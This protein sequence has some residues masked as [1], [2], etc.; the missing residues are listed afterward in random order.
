MLQE[1][2]QGGG[3]QCRVHE[4][5][6]LNSPDWDLSIGAV[7]QGLLDRIN[8]GE[9]DV[10]LVT[11]PCSTWSRV[12]GANCRGPPAIRS[13]AYPWG[14]PWLSA[15][16]HK[17][18]DLGNILVIFMLDVL[19][20]L[21]KHP[22]TASGRLVII[23]D[24]RP[25]DLG[26][27]RCEEDGM[28][29]EP[30]SIWQ[31]DRMRALLTKFASLQL[32]TVVFNQSCWG[33]P[34]RKPTRLISN[35]EAL[36]KWG[37]CQW[38]I[39][40]SYRNYV[41]PILDCSCKTTVTLARSR[42]DDTFRTS[43][44]SIYPVAMEAALAKA[45]MAQWLQ[46]PLLAKVGVGGGEEGESV[47]GSVQ[48]GVKR[49]SEEVDE[50]EKKVEVSEPKEKRGATMESSSRRVTPATDPPIQVGYKGETRALHDGAGLCSPG[51]WPVDRRRLPCT[52]RESSTVAWFGEAF[53]AWLMKVGED[54]AKA[55][56][57]A[58]AAGKVKESPFGEEVVEVRR[59]LGEHLG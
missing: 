4:I 25:E 53:E 40:D 44:T 9:F 15:R 16:H 35:L 50:Q 5:D 2:C 49:K 8:K 3:I 1:L 33:A 45:I 29:M 34:Y 46:A 28:I 14:F 43:N 38:P 57:W 48:R 31:L 12:R 11:P 21:G 55:I 47:A 6:I 42:E 17:D 13:R 27:I 10:V 20:A 58:M 52:E 22:R 23:F 56:F 39:F 30:A 54:K 24:E 26:A 41:G 18:A 32:F 19:E 37:A 59:S 7:Q 51:R 36:R